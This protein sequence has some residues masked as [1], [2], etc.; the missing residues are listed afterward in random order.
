MISDI[1][2]Y[3]DH[4]LLR[5]TATQD[6]IVTL[7]EEALTYS[8]AAVCVPPFYVSSA[9]SIL[10]GS[11]VM[12]CT[13]IGFPLGYCT[14][15]AK[16][17]QARHALG[18]GAGEL[19]MVVNQCA[20]KNGGFIY[21]LDEIKSIRNACKDKVLKVIV[22]TCNLNLSEKEMLVDIVMR[23]GADFIKTSTGFG[24]KGAD[25]AD[26]RLFR[27]IAGD[28]LKIK[29]SGGI[30]DYMAAETFIDAGASRI[31]TSKGVAIVNWAQK[32]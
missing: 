4:S 24:A 8:F 18:D 23:S 6:E 13:V 16:L 9:A 17:V 29:A 14:P 11:D 7:C 2:S 3:I 10:T 20:V 19:D 22:E 15:D 25:A 32:S 26:V 12:V 5:P 21:I 31:G 28:A 30:R 27:E 1:A